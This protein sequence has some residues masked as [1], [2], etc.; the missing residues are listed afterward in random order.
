MSGWLGSQARSFSSPPLA[1]TV[2]APR[3]I[4]EGNSSAMNCST[5]STPIGLAAAAH[6]TGAIRA[7]A[8]PSF[9]PC[10]TSSSES[11]PSSRYFSISASSDSATASISFSRNG[12][13]LPEMSSGHSPSVGGRAAPR[14]GTP[15]REQVGDALEVV[16][17][18]EREL[19][20]RD[21]RPE[22]LHELLER[23]LERRALAV[24]LVDQDR[25]RQAG[26]DREL[27]RDLGLHLDAV[28]GGDDEHDRVDRPDRR[29]DVADEVRVARARPGR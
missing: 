28:D 14:S 11:S 2:T 25:A 15:S 24:E 27:P 1:M 19:E 18:A 10:T 29:A 20:R 21:L 23:P 26:L 13:A 6:S 12:S 22:R 5:R 4:G 7:S 16:L 9:T 17:L 3:S 8:N